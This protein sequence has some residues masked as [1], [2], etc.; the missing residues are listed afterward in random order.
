MDER[1]KI[2]IP[3]ILKHEGGYVNDPDDLGGETN[4]GITKR[5][6][7]NMDIKN[8]TVGEARDIYYK[9]FYV[10]MNLYYIKDDLLALHVMDMGVNAGKKTAVKLLQDLLF[11]C[12]SDGVIGPVSAQAISYAVITTNLVEAYKAKRIQYYYKVSLR[13]NNKK[14]L[15]GWINRVYKTEL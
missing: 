15:K 9:D 12:E 14:F 11:G 5:R 3:V 8:L 7:P 13:R 2:F 6:Y 4:F 1:F 10:P